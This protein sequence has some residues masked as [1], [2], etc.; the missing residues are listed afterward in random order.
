MHSH[1]DLYVTPPHCQPA[2]LP[3]H[4]LQ[5]SHQVQHRCE[6]KQHTN[7][8]F[9]QVILT[10]HHTGLNQFLSVGTDKHGF[11]KKK[12]KGLSLVK[13]FKKSLLT[14]HVSLVLVFDE[15][16]AAWLSRPLVVHNVDLKMNIQLLGG[17]GGENPAHTSKMTIA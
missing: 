9:V 1:I 4:S 12:K 8:I 5:H 17:G 15:S 10:I 2:S 7:T 16:V 14:V 11:K 6:K 3:A 13:I